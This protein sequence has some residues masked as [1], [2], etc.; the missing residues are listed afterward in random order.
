VKIVLRIWLESRGLLGC[1]VRGP[2]WLKME[3]VWTSEKFLPYH[4]TTRRHNPENLE[5]KTG[6]RSYKLKYFACLCIECKK[7]RTF[8]C[9]NRIFSS[10]SSSSCLILSCNAPFWHFLRALSLSA[11]GTEHRSSNR[12]SISF[13]ISEYTLHTPTNT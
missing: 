11:S 6:E 13:R 4:N 12:G 8:E 10:S 7:R 1:D 3:A 5:L 2:C 9:S